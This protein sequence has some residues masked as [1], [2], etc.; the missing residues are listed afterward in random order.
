MQ[1]GGK[2]WGFDWR[3]PGARLPGLH[4]SSKQRGTAV[5]SW[6]VMCNNSAFTNS[7]GWDWKGREIREMGAS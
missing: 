7:V 5:G 3:A 1:E 2:R 6:C 4:N